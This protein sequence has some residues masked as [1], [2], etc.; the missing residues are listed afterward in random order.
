ML[1]AASNQTRN[2][3]AARL[4]IVRASTIFGMVIAATINNVFNFAEVFT[5]LFTSMIIN[6]S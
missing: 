2:Y 4:E 6:S 5:P 1:Y 3:V